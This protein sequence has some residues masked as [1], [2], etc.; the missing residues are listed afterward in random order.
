MT[1]AQLDEGA[2]QIA[3][4][5]QRLDE[6]TASA[7]AQIED[8][9]VQLMAG[10]AQLAAAQAQIEDNERALAAA[11]EQIEEKAAELDAAKEAYAEGQTTY[12]DGT[13][14]L[15]KLA[16]GKEQL[17]QYLPILQSGIPLNIKPAQAIALFDEM[18]GGYL[19][20]EAPEEDSP[21][22]EGYATV[23][24]SA[25]SLRAELKKLA[26]EQP[27]EDVTS[28]LAERLAAFSLTLD[29]VQQD[30]AAALADASAQLDAASE[31]IAD[32]EAALESARAQADAG[33]SQ[34]DEARAQYEAAQQELEA[35][36]AELEAGRSEL[37]A[38][39]ASAEA[40]IAAA[41]EELAAREAEYQDA[42][43]EYQAQKPEAEERLAQ[44]EADLAEAQEK[45]DRLEA[46]GYSASSRREVPGGDGYKIYA[47]VAQIVDALA[48]VFPI[49]LYFIAALVT[50]TTM[51]RMVDEERIGAGTLKALGYGD[52]DVALKFLVYGLVSSMVGT[53]IGI[54]A[55]HTL[56]PWIVYNAYATKFVLPPILLL[57][58][59]VV[60]IVAVVL[61]LVSAVLP[62][63]LAVRSEL[64]D[65]P[66]ELLLPKP[67]GVW[68]E[69]PARA[70][71]RHL[72]PSFVH[73]QG[74]GAQPLPL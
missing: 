66:S 35:K 29:Q 3:A 48:R 8:G 58:D 73:A 62:A 30:G 60:S 64:R 13:A 43:A 68:L 22:F 18:A 69:D 40:Q 32:G 70:H 51:T 20:I 4:N 9:A 54:I 34:L 49:L 46:P 21:L 1:R 59:P 37:A 53:V 6:E 28:L 57:F 24:G 39:T 56:L 74:H 71:P 50:F 65:K 27:D 2:A 19:D 38:T 14:M 52:R 12:E 16:A 55:G 25:S 26:E 5:E 72:E 31:K 61:G 33:A 15:D 17:D 67:P 7:Q 23:M 41:K 10:E 11:Q 47:T 63:W 42:L 36:R 45:L 44:A